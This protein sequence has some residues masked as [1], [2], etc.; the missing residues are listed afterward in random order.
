[1]GDQQAVQVSR[2]AYQDRIRNLLDLDAPIPEQTFLK[3]PAAPRIAPHEAGCWCVSCWNAGLRYGE[4]LEQK[5][6]EDL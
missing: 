5:R 2:T 4:W 6:L 1:M 3:P